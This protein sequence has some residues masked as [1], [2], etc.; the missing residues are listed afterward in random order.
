[1]RAAR[2]KIQPSASKQCWD[3]RF[4]CPAAHH[5]SATGSR[6]RS[7]WSHR[8]PNRPSEATYRPD[9]ARL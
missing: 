7:Y 4:G 1:M 5:K 9:A 2:G 6:S 8:R 3:S